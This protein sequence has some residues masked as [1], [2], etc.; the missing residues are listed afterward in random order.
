M[1]TSNQAQLRASRPASV[2]DADTAPRPTMRPGLGRRRRTRPRRWCRSSMRRPIGSCGRW[3]SCCRPPR[4]VSG[5]GWR[6]E[7]PSTGR[8]CS[9][10][11]SPTRSPGSASPSA[12]TGCSPTAASRPRAPVRVVLAVLGSMAVE[13]PVIEWVATHRKHHRFSDHPGRPAQSARRPCARVARVAARTL[14]RARRLDVP[15]QGHGQPGPL[16][17]GPARRP[18]P[19]LHQPDVPALGAGRAGPPVRARRRADRL[20]RRR[21]HG[22]AVGRRGARSSSCI[23]RP[24]ASTRCATSSAG[25]RSPPAIESRNL[26]WLAPLAVRRGLAQQPPRLP[27]LGA[28]RAESMAARPRGVAHRRARALPSRV[29]CHPD[30][31]RAPASQAR[32]RSCRLAH[33]TDRDP[34]SRFRTRLRAGDERQRPLQG[35]W[36][37]VGPASPDTPSAAQRGGPVSVAVVR[38]RMDPLAGCLGPA[39]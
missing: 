19:A 13:G 6:G 34:R 32:K 35:A 4:S 15:R 1:S 29:G 23:T 25:D 36:R 10:S 20:D 2:L 18:R 37:R 27:D 9:C 8:T 33:A 14:A 31:P 7:E 26:A 3:C 30:Q 39:R 38:D 12:T 11:R 28:P 17:Q 5:D 24:S 16:R 22:T 21:P